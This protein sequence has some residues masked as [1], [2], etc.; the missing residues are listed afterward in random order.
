MPH[1]RP[2]AD[3][4]PSSSSS[5]SSLLA[6]LIDNGE[7][8]IGIRELALVNGA[9][10]RLRK[11]NRNTCSRR[12]TRSRP[13]ER[14]RAPDRFSVRAADRSVYGRATASRWSTNSWIMNGSRQGVPVPAINNPE[15][16]GTGCWKTAEHHVRVV[17][18]LSGSGTTQVYRLSTTGE[19]FD[20][21]YILLDSCLHSLNNGTKLNQF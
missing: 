13:D 21:N 16:N 7:P 4:L 2:P 5:S 20:L 6:S 11:H 18:T 9:P 14:R 17:I 8:E 3:K 19:H 1:T 12:R 10:Y 15:W